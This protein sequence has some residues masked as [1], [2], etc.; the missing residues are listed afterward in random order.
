MAH[1]QYSIRDAEQPPHHVVVC[2][3]LRKCFQYSI[4]DAIYELASNERIRMIQNFQYS[5]RDAGCSGFLFLWVF[6][7]LCRHVQVSCGGSVSCSC[8]G[9]VFCV[10]APGVAEHILAH[11]SPR[12]R[13]APKGCTTFYKLDPRF[14]YLTRRNS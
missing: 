3:K 7:Y 1:F 12:R 4:R 5:I 8:F 9:F 10:G 14:T 2:Y 6:K 13:R 11:F